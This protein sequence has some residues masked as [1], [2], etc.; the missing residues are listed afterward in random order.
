MRTAQ[1]EVEASTGVNGLAPIWIG[2]LTLEDGR[3]VRT[4]IDRTSASTAESAEAHVRAMWVDTPWRFE[5]VGIRKGDKVTAANGEFK[6][7]GEV[8]AIL[9]IGEGDFYKVK[10]PKGTI[11]HLDP[12][13]IEKQE[14]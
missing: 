8:I 9:N 11:L 4:R 3:Q 5:T 6:G 7:V 1:C 12:S 14:T 13:E 2:T 10:T